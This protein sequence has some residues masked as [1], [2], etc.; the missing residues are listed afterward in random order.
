MK[1]QT[2]CN[3]FYGDVNKVYRT[4]HNEGLC[5]FSQGRRSKVFGEKKHERACKDRNFVRSA[6][7]GVMGPL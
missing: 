1:I 2:S 3:G 4:S 6:I 7:N 5:I